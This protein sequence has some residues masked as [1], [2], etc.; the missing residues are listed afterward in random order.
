METHQTTAA[1]EAFHYEW[2]NYCQVAYFARA[3]P[4][5]DVRISSEVVMVTGPQMP[6]MEVNHAGLLRAEPEKADGLIREITAHYRDLGLQPCVAVSP[7]CAPGDLAQ[8]LEAHGYEKYGDPEI[9]LKLVD[10]SYLEKLNYPPGITVRQIGKAELPTFCKLMAAAFELP[11]DMLPA[12]QYG[13]EYTIDLPGMNSYIAYA[14]EVPVGCVSMNTTQGYSAIGS[15]GVLPGAR[16]LGASYALW[17]RTY[18]DWKKSGSSDYV[19]Q[20]VLPI[21]A[22]LLRMGGCRQLFTRTYYVQP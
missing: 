17:K 18:E 4:G 10:A 19:L 20:T 16:R 8:R 6:T 21:L 5:I 13:L 22:R 15:G 14:G 9:W 12:L 7:A 3:V 11:E 2:A 1:D